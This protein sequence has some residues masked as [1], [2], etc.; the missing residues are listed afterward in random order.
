MRVGVLSIVNLV[1]P[2]TVSVLFVYIAYS[3][4]ETNGILYTQLV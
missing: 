3:I 4:P 1:V 2:A